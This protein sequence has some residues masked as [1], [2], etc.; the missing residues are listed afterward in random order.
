MPQKPGSDLSSHPSEED[1]EV[2]RRRYHQYIEMSRAEPFATPDELIDRL[3]EEGATVL[4]CG[5]TRFQHAM[6]DGCGK[7]E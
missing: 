2:S 3:S 7:V 5:H 4:D 1:R 6:A